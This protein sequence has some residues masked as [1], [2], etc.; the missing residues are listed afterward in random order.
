MSHETVVKSNEHYTP[1]YVFEAL[2]TSFDL[3]VA[4]PIDMQH[5][6]VPTTRYF[7]KYHDGLRTGWI[8]FV[9]MNPPFGNQKNKY[10]WIYKFVRHGNGVA[11]MPDRTSAPWWQYFANNVDA[12]LFVKGK[13]KFV[14]PNGEIAKSPTTG[15][16]LFAIGSKGIKALE[17]AEK[18]GLGKMY[19]SK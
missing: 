3:D 10:E 5:I 12:I 7:N 4:C 14:Q 6:T 1:S 2:D 11:L 18:N 8:G 15:T 17:N 19:R 13:I 16:T 9:W